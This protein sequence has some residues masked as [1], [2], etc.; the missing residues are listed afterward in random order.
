MRGIFGEA[1]T[2]IPDIFVKGRYRPSDLDA[3]RYNRWGWPILPNINLDGVPWHQ[4]PIPRRLHRHF[5]QTRGW[6]GINLI[7]RCT[8]GAV[9]RNS[10][11]IWHDRNSRRRS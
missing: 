6:L 2:S 11:R 7:D 5:V 8:C 10:S 3:E 4:A 9:S 1:D